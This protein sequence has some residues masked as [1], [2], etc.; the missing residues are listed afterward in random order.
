MIQSKKT[1]LLLQLSLKLS[2][3]STSERLFHACQVLEHGF[4]EIGELKLQQKMHTGE[5]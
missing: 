3:K 5:N 1:L 4:L 2:S